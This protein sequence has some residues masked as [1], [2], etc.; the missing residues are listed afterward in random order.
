[1]NDGFLEYKRQVAVV[2]L[3]GNA[4]LRKEQPATP[5]TQR[6]N[7]AQAL[8]NIEPL[9]G[10]YDSFALTHGNGPQ[11]GNDLIR[12]HAAKQMKGL[13]RISLSDC[14]ANTQGRIGHWLIS[15]MKRN[16]K[17]KDRKIANIITHVFVDQ[18]KFLR[19][20]YTKYVGP[21]LTA[22][23]INWVKAKN[24][25]IIYKAPEGQSGMVRRVV[26][27]PTPYRIE[28]ISIINDLIMKGVITI[29]CGGGG[30]PVYDPSY[31]GN[32]DGIDTSSEEHFISADVVIDKDRASAVLASSLLEMNPDCD[33][34]LIILTDVKG[35][36]KTAELRTE[37]F[38]REMNLGE[39]DYF[40]ENNCLDSGSIKPKLESIRHF[41]KKG[42]KHAYLG[43]LRDFDLNNPGTHFYSVEQIQLFRQ[44]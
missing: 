18:N 36:Y 1:M 43:S 30:I 24:R 31:D 23:E 3:G 16:P 11:V 35:L 27:S 12:A 39:I 9:L 44:A 37:D 41:L 14:G 5:E 33:V 15:E 22:G 21:W 13:S 2:A 25:G 28:E 26:P 34:H 8:T 38:I 29:C 32:K 10:N 6:E 42:G 40:L 7:I 19:E 4:I 20:E 17:F